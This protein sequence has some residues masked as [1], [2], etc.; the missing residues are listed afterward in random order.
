MGNNNFVFEGL[1]EQKK[2]LDEMLAS[3]PDME[4]RMQKVVRSVL[5]NARK[6]MET[7]VKNDSAMRNDPRQAYRAIRNIVYKRLLGGNISILRK[8]K[9][10]GKTS[11]YSPPRTLKSGQR[12][13]NRKR[14]NARTI[15]T[16]TY[17]STD[18][19]FILFW[20]NSGTKGRN[21][22]SFRTDPHRQ[23]VKRGSQGGDVNKYGKTFNTGKRGSIGPRNIFGSKL[24]ELGQYIDQVLAE[25]FKDLMG[26]MSNQP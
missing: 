21:L 16:N 24:T 19:G 2:K 26:E 5:A 17:G 11:S 9:A 13:G 22:Q 8:K 18:R 1:E 12:G 15:R 25:E 14:P 6:W 3:N 23:N 4:R 20:I 7:Q 10:S